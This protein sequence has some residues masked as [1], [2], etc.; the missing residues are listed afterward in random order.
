MPD[1]KPL[2]AIVWNGSVIPD[3]TAMQKLFQEEM[4][5]A[6]YVVGDFDCHVINP[7]YV[8]EGARSAPA[9]SGRNMTILLT[10]SGFVKYGQSRSVE[11]HA[12]SETFVLTPNPASGNSHSRNFKEWLIQSQSFRLVS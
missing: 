12:F 11:P 1:G 9:K 10:I 5:R 4:P 2:P 3:P 8:A 7:S 6:E